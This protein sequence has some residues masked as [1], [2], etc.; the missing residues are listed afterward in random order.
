MYLLI[1]LSTKDNIHLALFDQST[2]V[3]K[4]Y[5]GRNKE[6]LSSIDSLLKKQ[7]LSNQDIEGIMVV[8]GAGGFTSTRIAMVVANTFAYAL[9]IP[10]LA[11]QENQIKKIQELIPELIKQ[12]IG[13]YISASYSGQPNITKPKN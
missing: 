9:K 10:V 5:Q 1:N 13:Q 6:L 2:I 7:K 8:V 4:N 11:I 3:E 12:P